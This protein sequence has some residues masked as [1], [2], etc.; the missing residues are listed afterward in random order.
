MDAPTLSANPQR[1]NILGAIIVA[2]VITVW[3][4]IPP[5][6]GVNR[7]GTSALFH[8]FRQDTFY[9]LSVAANSKTGFYTFDGE[10]PTTGFH[11]LWQAYL[12]KLFELAP[13]DQTF[14]VHLTFW[15]GFVATVLGYIMAGLA[16]Y[17]MTNSK[18]L[19]VLMVP[20]FFNLLFLF[21][22]QFAGS[23]WSFMNGMESSLTVLFGGALFLLLSV[24]YNDPEAYENR[25][26]FYVLLG[27]VLSLMFLSRLDDIFVMVAFALCVLFLSQRPKP[28]R[29]VNALLLALPTALALSLYLGFNFY[30]TEMLLPIS[31]TMKAGLAVLSNLD[32]LYKTGSLQ[33]IGRSFVPLVHLSNLYRQI[34]IYFPV[35]VAIFFML[36]LVHG[37]SKETR[38][39][40]IFLIALL[41]SICFKALYN[42][43][44][45]HVNYQGVVWY[46]VFSMLVINFVGLIILSRAYWRF[47]EFGMPVKIVA[48]ATLVLYFAAHVNIMTMIAISGETLEYKFWNSRGSI[49]TELRN[50]NPHTKIVEYE[51]GI[52]NYALGI[53]TLHGI[54]FVVDRGAYEAKK[55]RKLLEYAYRHGYNTIGSLVYIRL[56]NEQMTSSQIEQVLRRSPDFRGENLQ[57]FTYSVLFIHK[58]TGATFISFEPKKQ[59]S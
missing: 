56:P 14:Q 7:S 32:A 42:V 33:G 48:L 35:L 19:A 37:K 4:L 43:V 10:T 34:Q 22:F 39:K 30:Q 23:P 31:G 3:L 9:Y 41:V 51:D 27:I 29:L 21:V 17:A 36:I 28:E 1:A 49:S 15:V 57:D 25:K 54:G 24:H 47:C 53:P 46:F 44:N 20:G 40:N 58:E 55:R 45:V 5:L 11:P 26:G 52:I 59:E 12:T 18:L 2:S 6:V 38:R 8:F 50:K 13:Q 16:V